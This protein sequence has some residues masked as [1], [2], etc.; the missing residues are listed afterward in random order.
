MS[1]S[2]LESQFLL[3]EEKRKKKIIEIQKV[4]KKKQ[5]K[6][7][8]VISLSE[9]IADEKKCI[10][11]TGFR[12]SV[13]S[14]FLSHFN[15]ALQ[16]D[17]G[18]GAGRRSSQTSDLRGIF[19]LNYL[20]NGASLKSLSVL[21]GFNCSTLE[22]ILK[23][24]VPKL[25]P[26]LRAIS[27][28]KSNENSSIPFEHFQNCFSA[29]DC[30]FIHH[31]HPPG[32]SFDQSK[33]YYSVKHGAYGYKFLAIVNSSGQL[34]F[35]SEM[36]PAGVHDFAMCTHESVLPRVKEVCKENRILAD[37]GFIGLNNHVRAIIPVKCSRTRNLTIEEKEQNLQI[38]K[39]RIVVENFFGRLKV[40]WTIFGGKCNTH[41]QH[42]N[43]RFQLA[44]HLTNFHIFD[45]PLRK[46]SQEIAAGGDDTVPDIYQEVENGEMS[47][48]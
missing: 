44:A 16:P 25:L 27:L 12:P 41:A 28:V 7:K 43:E 9:I 39:S 48:E 42:L 4:E 35:V 34:L 31:P 33:N 40:V 38:A 22:K 18:F 1:N 15:T 2:V 37:K 3:Q 14:Q 13:L 8:E 32:L 11:F 29:I 47:G 6:E 17:S 10:S 24:V 46:K 5:S 36:F 20:R 30:T 26:Q 21:F 45:K 23:D 19:V